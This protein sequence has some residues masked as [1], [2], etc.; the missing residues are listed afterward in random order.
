VVG[1]VLATSAPRTIEIPAIEVRSD[2]QRLGITPDGTMEVPEPGPR[3]DDVGW[4]R[5]SPTPGS[6]GP[7]VLVGHVDSA[8]NGPSV[9]YRLGSLRRNDKVRVTRADGTVAVFAVDS[10][11]RFRKSQFPTRLVYGNTDHAALRL[12]T[13]GGPIE[14]DSGHYRD[15]IVVLA[16]LI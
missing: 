16:S 2:V 9:F 10:V 11:R 1:P 8:A 4:Y 5:H 14:A 13:C 7:A 6:L 15:N 3:Y 12:I